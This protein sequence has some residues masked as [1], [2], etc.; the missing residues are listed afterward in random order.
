MQ[1]GAVAGAAISFPGLLAACD[2]GTDAAPPTGATATG[3]TA[4]GTGTAPRFGGH[5]T[6]GVSAASASE[7]LDPPLYTAPPE[8][9]RARAV[10]DRIAERRDFTTEL[11]LAEELEAV[12]GDPTTW[13]MTL[14]SGVQ[15]HDGKS[16]TSDD[17][18]WTFERLGRADSPTVSFI[19]PF[20]DLANTRRVDDL[21]IE[22][23]LKQPQ[24]D[25]PGFLADLPFLYIVQDGADVF[26]DAA[27]MVGTGPYKLAEFI[28]G[29]RFLL[30]KNADYWAGEPYIDEIE[31][32][33]IDRAEQLNA[34]LAGQL[35]VAEEVAASQVSQLEGN[36]D[37][38]VISLPGGGAP[39]FTMRLDSAP[40]D[41]VRVRQ[42]LKYAIDRQDILDKVY[43]GRGTL[44][45]DM[46]GKGWPSYNE[47]IA[48][49][50]YDPEQARAL[51]ADAGQENLEVELITAVWTDV[52][53]LFAEHAK[54]AGITIN[55]NRVPQDDIYN[56]D[57]YYLK[58]PFTETDWRTSSFE[59]VVPEG[60]LANAV[61]NETAWVFPE[62]DERFLEAF[63]VVDEGD[64]NDAYLQLHA[65]I[66]E[67]GGYIIPVWFD[68]TYAA[69]SRVH[70]IEPIAGLWYLNIARFEDL[71]VDE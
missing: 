18:L 21:T 61:A 13:L 50:S 40:F 67:E 35:D 37:F 56:T 24:G 25:F 1:R 65:E 42:A 36:A 51:L 6:I 69:S 9:Y 49:Y 32:V 29:E 59:K 64:R 19:E 53:T 44:G 63:A 8:H 48:Q 15:F 41:D 26:L 68:Y 2:T 17:V 45:N 4:T 43:L 54:A 22:F 10:F 62:W 66:S 57:L 16:L 46:F 47:E 7:T 14:R 28:P 3:A 11:E 27:D 58:A 60:L 34:L 39:F 30:E 52:A 20:I 70:G 38:Q 5:L 31:G 71:W 33:S 55:L 12:G 23:A